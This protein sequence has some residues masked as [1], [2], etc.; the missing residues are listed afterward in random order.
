[1]KNFF[2]NFFGGNSDNLDTAASS[3]ATTPSLSGSDVNQLYND[4]VD[5]NLFIDETFIGAM[6]TGCGAHFCL[7]SMDK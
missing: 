3:N 5:D 6:G 2:A 1:M 4:L 7:T